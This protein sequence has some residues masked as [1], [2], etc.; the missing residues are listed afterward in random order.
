MS[1]DLHSGGGY[2]I[3]AVQIE[4]K[5]NEDENDDDEHEHR[6]SLLIKFEPSVLKGAFNEQKHN[7]IKDNDCY[8]S[9]LRKKSFIYEKKPPCKVGETYQ[10]KAA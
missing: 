1:D 9:H 8:D 2:S 3:Q 6:F 5:E 4:P 7:D 10:C